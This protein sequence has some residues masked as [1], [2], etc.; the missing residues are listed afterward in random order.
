MGCRFEILINSEGSDLSRSECAA[1]CEEMRDLVFDWHR[2]LSVF[3]SNS[4]VSRFNQSKAGKSFTLDEDLLALCLMCEQVKGDTGGV[5]NIAAGTL[6]EAHGFRDRVVDCIDD[7]PLLNPFVINEPNRTIT[8]MDDRIS[9]D[10]GAIAKGFMLDLIRD[11]L[12]EVGIEQ[13]FIHG[14]TS[15]ALGLGAG[16]N[17]D[18]GH[19]I[20]V[21][22]DGLC[23]GVSETNARV[24]QQG[25]NKVCHVMDPRTLSPSTSNVERVVCV[26]RSGAI[27]DAYSTACCIDPELIHQLG[28]ES[29]TLLIFQLDQEPIV[30][31][32]LGVVHQI[33]KDAQ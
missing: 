4:F 16:W 23:I 29:C 9:I 33:P 26:H 22:I 17:I 12:I 32:P 24:I 21:S 25:S 20:S 27:A 2:R 30:H 3:E 31:D 19:S 14:G 5:F 18:V 28:D 8:K 15:S 13:A 6:M 10:F 7:L 11:E 1:V